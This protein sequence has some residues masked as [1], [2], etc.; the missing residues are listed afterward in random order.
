MPTAWAL[1]LAC[2][3]CVLYI[4]PSA[5]LQDEESGLALVVPRHDLDDPG[6]WASSLVTFNVHNGMDGDTLFNGAEK[7]STYKDWSSQMNALH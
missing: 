1:L 4:M 2:A 6:S 7:H 5:R 3:M